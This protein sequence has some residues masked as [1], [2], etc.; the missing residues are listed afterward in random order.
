MEWALRHMRGSDG[1][2]GNANFTWRL[3]SR[4]FHPKVIWWH[5]YGVYIGS[6]NLTDPAWNANCEAGVVILEP[7]LDGAE[8]RQP[9]VDFFADVHSQSVELTQPL[10]KDA[11]L[12]LEAHREMEA[13]RRKLKA[14]FDASATGGML[15]RSSLASVTKQPRESSRR[16][17]FLK[18][19][20]ETLNNLFLIQSRLAEPKN[21]PC[22]VPADASPGI[23]TD[24]FLHAY[25]YDQVREGKNYPVEEYFRT[26]RS[27]PAAA[28]DSALDWW[29]STP[30][31]PS[32]EEKVFLDWAPTHRELLTKDR[33]A[34]M[35]E[36]EFVRIARRVHSLNNH[37][38]H[39]SPDEVFGEEFDEAEHSGTSA[40]C[41][42]FCQQLYYERN[43]LNWQP[44]RLLSYLLF[45]GP[46]DKV[47]ERLYDCLYDPRY[48]M[49]GLSI[50]SLGEFVGYGLP[51][52]YPP[53]NDRTNKALRALGFDV[54]VR[55][56]TRSDSFARAAR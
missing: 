52:H 24:Q 3:V 25:Y 4:H 12:L 20:G 55:T 26:H 41:D 54:R 43:V 37:A 40:K 16:I 33:L 13:L 19:W 5:G 9:L 27:N 45:G 36:A 14:E 31:A 21:R 18:E 32:M 34:K 1:Q 30:A 39:K 56:P 29:R 28:L 42:L 48:K 17:D 11:E 51:D 15:G 46:P 8:L 2:C 44:P 23:H 49:R 35:T 22:W 10:Y 50:S 53:R 38:K 47:P 7:E 6:A